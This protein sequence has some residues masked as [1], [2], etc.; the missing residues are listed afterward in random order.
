MRLN[1]NVPAELERIIY[2]ALE[3]DRNLRY[4]SSEEIRTDLQ[5]L[6]RDTSVRVRASLP[7]GGTN[8]KAATGGLESRAP[9]SGKRWITAVGVLVLA[10][11]AVGIWLYRSIKSTAPSP[12]TVAQQPIPT[13][14]QTPSIAVLPFVDMS[15]N[16]D[17]EYFSDGLAEELLN[18]LSQIPGLRVTA[19][20]SS[21]SFKGKNARISDIG[22]ELNV[23]SILE[24]SVRKDGKNVR[25]TV[26]LIN[27]KDGFH[28]WSETYDKELEDVFTVQEEIARKVAG[29]LKVTLLGQKIFSP[30]S[31][32]VNVEAYNAYLKGRYFWERQTKE[33]L[34]KAVGYFQKAIELDP[35]YA[36]GW[37]GLASTHHI[38]AVNAYVP[39]DEGFRKA[40]HEVE[41]A[42]KLDPHLAQ[43]HARMGWI[44]RMHDWDWTG[45]N[46]SCKRALE[47][48]PENTT[49]L[50]LAAALTGTLGRLEEAIKL[51][52][53]AI[54]LDPLNAISYVSLGN[55]A[56][57]AG[58][59]KEAEEAFRKVLE[60][61]PQ[62]PGAHMSLGQIYLAQSKPGAALA[63]M[64]KEP[65]PGW[66]VFGLALAYHAAGKKK[67]ADAAM[68]E[69]SQK[70]QNDYAF[71]IAELHAFRDE[72]DQAF[73][74]LERSYAQHD[75]GL[76]GMK[77]DPLLRSIKDDP[78]YTAFLKKMNL[79]VD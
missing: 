66:K 57:R 42:L 5:R 69:L 27:V 29:A 56:Y 51:D 19:R 50:R 63:E 68:A 20:T 79:P 13:K 17:Q 28:L 32:N 9:S 18:D 76:P 23:S 70:Y 15:P 30:L 62:Y 74:W 11:L 67:E 34:E 26:Q 10:M 25:I 1:E 53:R 77:G 41:N 38:Q 14:S 39:V 7:A 21:F 3:K 73:H 45:A 55:Y 35:G 75:G 49:A 44:Q 31:K 58:R 71:Q 40:R 48:E 33:D 37:V 2:K 4:H 64:H 22:K 43:A 61:S 54:E 65:E 36:P 6:K 78:R 59:L 12:A 52:H 8:Q 60:L 72:P 24:G 47:L 46:E 16:K